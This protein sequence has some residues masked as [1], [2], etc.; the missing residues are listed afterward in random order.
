[1]LATILFTEHVHA[2]DKEYKLLEGIGTLSKGASVTF[3]EYVARVFDYT[4]AVAA[5]LAMLMLV[6]S[7]VQY[8]SAGVSETAKSD[9]KKRMWAAFYGLA[10]AIVGYLILETINPALVN[11]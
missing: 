8:A 4:V 2:A 7:G 5:L 10:L 9:A 11:F 3:K 6:I 1:M